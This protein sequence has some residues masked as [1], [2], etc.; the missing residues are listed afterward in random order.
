MS[1]VFALPIDVSDWLISM[2]CPVAASTR[3]AR[4]VRFAGFTN[5][6]IEEIINTAANRKNKS[7]CI[8][9]LLYMS[10]STVMPP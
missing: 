5:K 4:I 1:H 3:L 6:E 8:K 2:I 7:A 9:K 10:I